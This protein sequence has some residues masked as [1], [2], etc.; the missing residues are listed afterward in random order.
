MEAKY[1][2]S[3]KFPKLAGFEWQDPE[4]D[5]DMTLYRD[6]VRQGCTILQITSDEGKPDINSEFVYSVGFYLNLKHP[7]F[8]IM[9]ILGDSVGNFMKSLFHYVESGKTIS[10]GHTVRHDFGTDEKKMIAKW[11]SRER[12]FDYLGWGCWFYRSLLWKVRP[13]A[14]HKFPVLQLFWPDKNGFYP[15]EPDCNPVAKR[16]QTLV[17]QEENSGESS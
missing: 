11:V 16:V 1:Q 2:D 9:G 10:E 6:I 13:I 14:E 17:S 4:N 15:W 7:E 5:W 8:L 3:I 12:Y